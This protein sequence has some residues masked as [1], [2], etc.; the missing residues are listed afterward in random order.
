MSSTVGG[1]ATAAPYQN[2]AKLVGMNWKK[3]L[4]DRRRR[5]KQAVAPITK[6]NIVRGDSVIILHGRDKGKTGKVTRVARRGHRVT[7]AGANLNYRFSRPEGDKPGG[8]YRVESPV[9]IS[10]VNLVDPSTQKGTRVAIKYDEAGAKVRV[11]KAS[12]AIIP[13]PTDTLRERARPRPST[14]GPLDT[15]PEAVSAVTFA[16]IEAEYA[17]LQALRAARRAQLVQ[18]RGLQHKYVDSESGLYQTRV[19]SYASPERE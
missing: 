6:W 2:W 16:G 18:A 1:I 3:I 5:N 15:P 17:E 13:W 10:N 9:H 11:A 4:R 7:V 12:G 8:V 14:P 19:G